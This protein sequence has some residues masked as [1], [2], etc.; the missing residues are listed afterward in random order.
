MH[1][2]VWEIIVARDLMDFNP[3]GIRKVMPSDYKHYARSPPRAMILEGELRAS[4]TK[5][6]LARAA[7]ASDVPF[8]LAKAEPSANQ[9]DPCRHTETLGTTERVD[10]NKAGRNMAKWQPRSDGQPTHPAKPQTNKT[11]ICTKV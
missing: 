9:G 7:T 2:V 11:P 5:Q 10:V 1:T 6:Q 3:M 4:I 8:F